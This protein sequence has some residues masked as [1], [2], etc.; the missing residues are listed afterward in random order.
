M[1]R[2]ARRRDRSDEQ[3]K[4]DEGDAER[5]THSPNH[6]GDHRERA[7]Q[8]YDDFDRI[9]DCRIMHPGILVR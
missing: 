6:E 7:Q 5:K 2:E 9:A 3:T 1:R 8:G 4:G